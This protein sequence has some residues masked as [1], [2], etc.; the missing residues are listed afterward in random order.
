M[1]RKHK[2]W[3]AVLLILLIAAIAG[4]VYLNSERTQSDAQLASANAML[5]EE[6]GKY[7]TLEEALADATSLSEQLTEEKEALQAEVDAV[8]ASLTEADVYKRQALTNTPVPSSPRIMI[9]SCSSIFRSSP[10][11]YRS[12]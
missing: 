6:R 10:A 5:E 8:N 11:R 7:L 4:V 1:E 2:I 3:L 9:L 12:S